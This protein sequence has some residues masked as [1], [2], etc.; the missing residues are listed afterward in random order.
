MARTGRNKL[1]PWIESLILKYS[2]DGSSS[3]SGRLKAHVIGVGQM[4][5][6]QAQTQ[7]SEGP[8]GLLFL[9][10]GVL[11]IPAILTS[12]AWEHLQEKEERE[13]FNSLLSAT[14]FIQDYKLQFHIAP[15]QT[16]SRFFLSVGEL[17]TTAAGPVKDC[18][19]CCTTLPSVRQKI[20]VT[21]RASLGQEVQVSQSQCGLNLTELLGEWQHDCLQAVQE[22]VRE[23]LMTVR[24]HPVNPLPSTSTSISS[25]TQQDT[26]ITTGWD[27]DRVRYKREKCFTVPINCLCIPDDYYQQ[28]QTP[29]D[30]DSSTP[31]GLSAAS[32]NKARDLPQ[33]HETAEPSVDD[34]E[35][36]IEDPSLVQVDCDANVNLQRHVEDNILDE[37]MITRLNES[38]IKPL[39]NPWDIFPPPG[40]TSSSIDT[41]PD[42]TEALP[43]VAIFTSTQI[44]FQQTSEPNSKGE[45][46]DLV[47]YQNPPNSSSLPI[48]VSASTST[49][50][51][52]PEPF[53]RPANP[54]QA[55]D[56]LCTE[57]EETNLIA[58]EQDDQIF[59]EE[60]VQAVERKPRK[61]KRKRSEPSVEDQTVLEEEE[62]KAQIS[63]SPPSWLFDSKNESEPE[64]GSSH[65]QGQSKGTALRTASTVHSDGKLFS[66][67]YQVSGKSLQG[68][69]QLKVSKSLVSWAVK[70]LV[71][72][73][74]ANNSHNTSTSSNQLSSDKTE[75]T[76]L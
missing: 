60:I 31:S 2:H 43:Q 38:E 23:K 68:L 50:V 11:Q 28:L 5:Q 3:T 52:P 54:F 59:E 14:V 33:V 55:T 22:E 4:S 45:Q 64:E 61:A 49:S 74:Q 8:P 58:L 17:A 35:W 18:T 6:S 25:L 75:V 69:S 10:D 66:Y 56:R 41:S 76:P 65:Q 30:V 34:A 51:S 72:P 32:K 48:T 19:P 26:F 9:S 13:S 20:C 29:L 16:K 47:P 42:V 62:E 71:A 40:D 27:V 67:S 7:G 15:E 73:K 1:S 46:S 44:P 24:G 53:T 12:S 36:R 39:S 70:Y 21:W 63:G 57:P 37:N